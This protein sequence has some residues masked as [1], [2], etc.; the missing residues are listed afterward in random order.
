MSDDTIGGV[1]AFAPLHNNPGKKDADYF[2]SRARAFCQIH[3]GKVVIFDDLQSMHRRAADVLAAI[4]AYSG[5]TKLVCVAFFNH[6]WARGIEAGFDLRAS[7]GMSPAVLA[8]AL[9]KKAGAGVI[10]P[11]YACSTAD[12]PATPGPTEDTDGAPGGDGGF[13]DQLRDALCKRGLTNCR[14]DA[15]DVKGDTTLNPRV[16]RFEGDGSFVGGYGGKWIVP[17]KLE[18]AGREVPNPLFAKW[19]AA[20]KRGLDMEFPFLGTDEIERRLSMLP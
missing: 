16:R 18:L 7:M 2:Q 19:T 3:G 4:T 17:P 8:D 14:V 11:L 10:V 9:S 6:G 15:H 20:L 13:A 5:P 1:L 12:D